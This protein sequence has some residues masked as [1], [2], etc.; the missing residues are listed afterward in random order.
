[1]IKEVEYRKARKNGCSCKACDRD[2]S[3]E[4]IISFTPCAGHCDPVHICKDCIKKMFNI[5]SRMERVLQM[6]RDIAKV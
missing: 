6:G 1:M 3:G 5:I 2:V 4:Y